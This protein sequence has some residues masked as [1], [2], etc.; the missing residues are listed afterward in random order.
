[1]CSIERHGRVAIE[2]ELE[3]AELRRA[4]SVYSRQE[5]RAWMPHA[6]A[7]GEYSAVLRMFLLTDKK[8]V[9]VIELAEL[10]NGRKEDDFN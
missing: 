8:H 1:M 6:R 2:T 4:W 5:T 7:C 10:A 9:V 3:K